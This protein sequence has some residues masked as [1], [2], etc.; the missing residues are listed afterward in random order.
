MNQRE[1]VIYRW[2]Q[3]LGI[4]YADLYAQMKNENPVMLD[5]HNIGTDKRVIDLQA[6]RKSILNGKK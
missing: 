2:T 4:Y 1:L 3:D 6:L 5:N